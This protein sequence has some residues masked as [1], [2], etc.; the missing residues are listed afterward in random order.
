MGLGD[1]LMVTGI[2]KIEKEKFPDRQ[3][4]IGNFHKK[5]VY[6]SIIYDNNPNITN[7]RQINIH[8]ACIA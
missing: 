7:P 4:V 8:N 2:A 5:L 6:H 3:I 1:D